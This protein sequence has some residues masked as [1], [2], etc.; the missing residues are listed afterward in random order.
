MNKKY[1]DKIETTLMPIAGKISANRYL[2]AIR[3]GFMLTMPL[4]IV[5]A[6]SLLLANLPIPGYANFMGNLF[7]AGWDSFFT[8]PY[9]CISLG[10]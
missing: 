5:G 2:L 10:I 4:L 3:D 8:I 6:M 7:G 1:M 9:N